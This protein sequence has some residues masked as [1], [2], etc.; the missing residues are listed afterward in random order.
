MHQGIS[1]FHH[2]L[3]H[4]TTKSCVLAVLGV[5][6]PEERVL[7]DSPRGRDGGASVS[8]GWKAFCRR[9]RPPLPPPSS[10]ITPVAWGSVV[11][12]GLAFREALECREY[13]MIGNSGGGSHF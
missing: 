6:L 12:F 4:K 9:E 13:L 5:H 1:L 11:I 7:G 10:Y 2:L 8:S 3:F